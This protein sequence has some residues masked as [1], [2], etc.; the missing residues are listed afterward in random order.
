MSI[1]SPG[2]NC[3]SSRKPWLRHP[4]VRTSGRE[5]PSA[6]SRLTKTNRL[7]S[8][9]AA[10]FTAP[11]SALLRISSFPAASLARPA[12][13]FSSRNASSRPRLIAAA[14][15]SPDR[16]TGNVSRYSAT[17]A[18]WRSARS[19]ARRSRMVSD[20]RRRTLG[21]RVMLRDLYA[22]AVQPGFKLPLE[23]LEGRQVPKRRKILNQLD[24]SLTGRLIV[25]SSPTTPSRLRCQNEK[26][27]KDGLRVRQGLKATQWRHRQRNSAVRITGG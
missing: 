14:S 21:V 12:R 17:T 23:R 3:P 27:P 4:P 26:I 19:R 1:V 24:N 6:S 16:A 5:R 11:S 13:T 2:A 10:S 8:V 25:K 7:R 9:D 18:A 20:R 22:Y 15:L